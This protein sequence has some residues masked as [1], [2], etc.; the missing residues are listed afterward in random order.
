MEPEL[1]IQDRLDYADNLIKNAVQSDS[2]FCCG[3]LSF[4]G[5]RFPISTVLAELAEGHRN[6]SELALDF[7]QDF[8]QLNALLDGLAIYAEWWDRLSDDQRNG[9]FRGL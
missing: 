4:R 7:K 1:T 8:T 5:S 3:R 6:L 2:N 9:L